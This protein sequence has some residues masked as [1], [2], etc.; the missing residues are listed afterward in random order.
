[1]SLSLVDDPG[2]VDDL[3]VLHRENELKAIV[4]TRQASP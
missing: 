4:V 3:Q 1:M 2:K